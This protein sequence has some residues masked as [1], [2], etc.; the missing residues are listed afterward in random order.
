MNEQPGTLYNKPQRH[1]RQARSIPGEQC[2]LGCEQHTRV[3]ECGHDSCHYIDTVSRNHTSTVMLTKGCAIQGRIG[4]DLAF[5]EKTYMND[6]SSQ[7]QS[8][9]DDSRQSPLSFK[10]LLVI[11]LSG[12]LGVRKREKRVSDFRRANGLHVFIAAVLYF[13]LIVAVLIILVSYIAR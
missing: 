11:I 10:E 2:A 6:R 13:A 3:F 9:E 1:E 8:D 5:V 7:Q 12:H 4:L